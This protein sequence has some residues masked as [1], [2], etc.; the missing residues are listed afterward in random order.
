MTVL[1]RSKRGSAVGPSP[2]E[3]D[4]RGTSSG[5]RAHDVETERVQRLRSAVQQVFLSGEMLLNAAGGTDDVEELAEAVA[6]QVRGLTV[7]GEDPLLNIND[8]AEHPGVSK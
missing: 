8:V 6:E 1:L 7:N 2:P 5:G 4:L 3:I